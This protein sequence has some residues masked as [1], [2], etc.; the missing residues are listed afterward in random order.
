MYVYMC[1]Y[2]YIHIY[3]HTYIYI[4]TYASGRS[5]GMTIAAQERLLRL[6]L[7]PDCCEEVE[8]L[9]GRGLGAPQRD[10][11]RRSQI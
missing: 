5:M 1:I 11:T 3:V 10:P 6:P 2:I 4:Y 7:R 8:T 9:P